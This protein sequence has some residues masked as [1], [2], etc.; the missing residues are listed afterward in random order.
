MGSRNNPRRMGHPR[1]FFSPNVTPFTAAPPPAATVPYSRLSQTACSSPGF[2]ISCLASF[3]PGSPPP[4]DVRFLRQ[5]RPFV[6]S[7]APLRTL[8]PPPPMHWSPRIRCTR[9]PQPLP[10]RCTFIQQLSSS[11][12]ASWD[13]TFGNPSNQINVLLHLADKDAEMSQLLAPER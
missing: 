11:F 1:L 10:T 8:P 13:N 9:S 6:P 7:I 12:T 5:P 4:F 3:S 2:T